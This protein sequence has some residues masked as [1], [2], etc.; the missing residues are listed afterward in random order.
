MKHTK[1]A[2]STAPRCPYCGSHSIL[3]SADGIYRSN[4]NHTMLY[5][6]RN[7]PSCDSYVRVI[8]G[9]RQP[10]GTLANGKLRALRH[11]AHHYFNKLYT[12]GSMTREDAYQWL[13]AVLGIPMSQTHIG[14]LGEYY[15]QLVIAESQKVLN[16]PETKNHSQ[17]GFHRHIPQKSVKNPVV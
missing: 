13:S 7:Y 2:R 3:R 11:E 17:T 6:C 1:R 12:Q 4:H 14:L 5:V 9:T 15:C 16:L 10:M 8:P